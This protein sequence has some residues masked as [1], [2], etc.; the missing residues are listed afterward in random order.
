M[1]IRY[2][3]YGLGGYYGDHIEINEKLKDIRYTKLHGYI[4]NHELKHSDKFDLKH[5]MK[6]NKQLIPLILFTLKHPKTWTS[7]SPIEYKEGTLYTDW[8]QLI[9]YGMVTAGII[10]LI[11]IL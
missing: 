8:N 11:K 4:L 10:I 1:E 6:L 2:V 3:K 7:F 9:L 5:D